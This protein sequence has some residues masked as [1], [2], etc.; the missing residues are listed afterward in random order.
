MK[1]MLVYVPKKP[2]LVGQGEGTS[3]CEN[4]FEVFSAIYAL[5]SLMISCI[6]QDGQI[7]PSQPFFACWF[8][9]DVPSRSRP[10]LQPT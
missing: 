9:F 1:E 6:G 3:G 8:C 2:Y 10:S 4:C 5:A 7:R